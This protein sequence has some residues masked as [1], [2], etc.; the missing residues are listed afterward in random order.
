MKSLRTLLVA[1]VAALAF[2]GVAQASGGSYT[3]DGGTKAEQAQVKGALNA[4]SFN[5]SL[6]PQTIVVHIGH[7]SES[8]ALPGHIWLDADLLDS[9]RF[10][11]GVVQHE[12]AHQVD[13]LL[14][15]PATRARL[16][17]LLGGSDWCY[18]TGGLDHGAYGCERFAS[19]LAWAYWQNSAN[20]MKPVAA[21]DESA[22]MAPA[23][24]RA[25]L[26]QILGSRTISTV[27]R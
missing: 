4:S 19:T 10:S 7:G 22:A 17:V 6:V 1:A 15:D 23:Q 8:E 18:G 13:F 21:G 5:W 11:W 26:A 27:K 25:L 20:S 14:F 24:F 3:F 16:N 12:Y 2:T 9:G